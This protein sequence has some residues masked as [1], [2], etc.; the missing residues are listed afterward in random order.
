LK[1]EGFGR[2]SGE[3]KEFPISEIAEKII[4]VNQF[5]EKGRTPDV[6]YSTRKSVFLAGSF[7]NV[8]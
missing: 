2:R 1:K 6:Y 7:R 5:P 8:T 3:K 4:Q